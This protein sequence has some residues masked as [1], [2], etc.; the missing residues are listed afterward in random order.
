MKEKLKKII[1]S[2]IT[3]P[4]VLIVYGILFYQ[5]TTLCMYGRYN[6]NLYI[7]IAC[8]LLLIGITIFKVIKVTKSNKNKSFLVNS[9]K[10][11]CL[12][13][14]V[15][16]IITSLGGFKIYKSATNYGGKLAWVID[17]INRERHV[18]FNNDNI[19]ENGVTGF[20]SD[21]NKKYE[22]PKKLYLANDFKL[23][24]EK[25]G[26]IT[27]VETFIY[28][29]DNNGNQKS[30]LISY[31]KSKSNKIKILMDGYAGDDYSNDK[32]VE[33]LIETVANIPIDK[34][35]EKW[36]AKE[37]GLL[38][39]GKRNWGYNTDGII[40]IGKNGVELPLY[41]E[42][43]TRD[44]TDEI[45]G[46][47]VSIY[48][49]GKEDIV[50]PIRY[51]LITDSYWREFTDPQID[52]D[53]EESKKELD[54]VSGNS[55][56][57]EEFY[58]KDGIRYKLTV[59]DKAAGQSFYIL[60]K[61]ID[62]GTKWTTV[63]HDPLNGVVG[64][65]SGMYFMD[66]TTGFVGVIRNGGDEGELYRTDDGGQSFNKIEFDTK[67]VSLGDGVKYKP[68]DFPTVPYEE[69][70]VLYLKV[71]QGADGDYKGNSSLLYSSKD[72]GKTWEYVKEV[73]EA[74]E[75]IG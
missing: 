1:I 48:I 3:D 55:S 36:D 44:I 16:I 67:E 57:P 51:N 19:Y 72:K 4:I 53:K 11:K 40:E 35:I 21:I 31:D 18:K 37:Y 43:N 62:G 60:D 64:G 69:D 73:N 46:Y 54:I 30:Y 17:R 10:W 7:F 71:E 15:F 23:K 41:D 52:R 13:I 63:N 20:F 14:I 58:L 45:V 70:G 9:K 59:M 29:K 2:L 39:A 66:E 5:L 61:T 47:T 12:S 28:G 65:I 38:Y 75:E 8:T 42:E 74:P 49:P 33:P 22:L 34:A 32:L 27:Y 56:N 68:Y 25:D 26:T 24:F 50:T 6:N